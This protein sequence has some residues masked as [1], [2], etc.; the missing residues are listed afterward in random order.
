VGCE[1]MEPLAWASNTKRLMGWKPWLEHLGASHIQPGPGL[2]FSHYNLA[3]QATIAGQGIVLGSAPIF[4][5][6][7]EAR[8]LIN[9]FTEKVTTNIRYDLVTTEKAAMKPE[10]ISFSEW[11]HREARH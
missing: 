10:V 8:L 4:R 7:V 1:S 3:V 9:P 5:R 11:I 2:R 6:L